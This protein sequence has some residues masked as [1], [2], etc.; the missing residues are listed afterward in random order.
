M[1]INLDHILLWLNGIACAVTCISILMYR[2]EGQAKFRFWTSAMA[3]VLAVAMGAV[4]WRTGYA[5]AVV[6]GFLKLPASY[7][8]YREPVDPAELLVNL[9]LCMA[10]LASR[11]N[12]GVLFAPQK[13]RRVSER[14]YRSIT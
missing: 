6:A 2:R 14:G 11:G 5:L 10:M 12:V 1:S 4:A 7:W 3:Y 13:L 9:L 8:V